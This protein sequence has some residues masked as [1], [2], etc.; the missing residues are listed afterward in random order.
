VTSVDFDHSISA[1]H[2][3]AGGGR[4]RRARYERAEN[5]T[6]QQAQRDLRDLATAGLLV[7]VGRTR[8]RYHI[9]GPRFPAAALERA[10]P[11]D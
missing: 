5:P 4:I 1:L 11:N 10:Y 2:D 7:P 8:A 6:H 3:V 9:E